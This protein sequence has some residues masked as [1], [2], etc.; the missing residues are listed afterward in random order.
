MDKQTTATKTAKASK[1]AGNAGNGKRRVVRGQLQ[2][3]LI[4]AVKTRKKGASFDV[5]VGEGGIIGSS[6]K[7]VEQCLYRLT[8]KGL[9]KKDKEGR[10]FAGKGQK[11]ATKV[12]ATKVKAKTK[13]AKKT[14]MKVKRKTRAKAKVVTARATKTKVKG[15]QIKTDDVGLANALAIVTGL[16]TERQDRIQYLAGLIQNG[17]VRT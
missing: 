11:K 6:Q 5:L 13:G 2:A 3:H 9:L 4:N 17:Q 12:K 8:T 15:T 16:P 7:S 14:K 10:Y 1:P